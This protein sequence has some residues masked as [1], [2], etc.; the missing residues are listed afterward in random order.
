M[1]LYLLWD[2][3]KSYEIGHGKT[4]NWDSTDWNIHRIVS[5]GIIM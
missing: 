2:K 5:L 3:Q 1:L 4:E